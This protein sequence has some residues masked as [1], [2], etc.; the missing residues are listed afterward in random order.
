VQLPR[1]RGLLLQARQRKLRGMVV[2]FEE[3]I[4]ESAMNNVIAQWLTAKA[5]G[6]NALAYIY[7][8]AAVSLMEGR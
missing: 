5:Q 1:L 3:R 7:F 8:L 6:A 2:E 4:R